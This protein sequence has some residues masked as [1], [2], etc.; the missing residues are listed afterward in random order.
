MIASLY[1]SSGRGEET[2]P[3]RTST[4][5]FVEDYFALVLCFVPARPAILLGFHVLK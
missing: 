1:P 4:R 5:C 2:Q 3:D